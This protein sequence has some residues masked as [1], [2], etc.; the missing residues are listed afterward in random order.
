MT[1]GMMFVIW[2]RQRE[3]QLTN[4]PID[5]C[6][7]FC[8]CVYVCVCVCV[9]CVSVQFITNNCYC[10]YFLIFR[11]SL[12]IAL[13]IIQSHFNLHLLY[14]QRVSVYFNMS[15]LFNLLVLVLKKV[16]YIIPMPARYLFFI[17]HT[18]THTHIHTRW[19]KSRLKPAGMFCY[20]V[21]F[22]ITVQIQTQKHCVFV[23]VLILA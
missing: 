14:Q 20:F 21:R 9:C 11:H 7:C 17:K 5:R 18:H 23:F 13:V 22:Y 15:Y 8:V 16:K 12:F 10:V 3:K 4:G 6:E 19:V 2:N 1:S